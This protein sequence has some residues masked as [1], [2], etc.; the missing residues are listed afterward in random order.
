MKRYRL[1][2][3]ARL[4]PTYKEL[5]QLNYPEVLGTF[6]RLEP[7]YKELKLNI[8]NRKYIYVS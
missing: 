4:E 2:F 1:K 6:Q 3:G 8:E 7:T 5:K